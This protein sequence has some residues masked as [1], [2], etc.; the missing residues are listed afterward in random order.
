MMYMPASWT[1]WES[2]LRSSAV[3]K[4]LLI[5]DTSVDQYP[6]QKKSRDSVEA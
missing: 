1:A 2:A 4:C 3:P 6:L 5:V